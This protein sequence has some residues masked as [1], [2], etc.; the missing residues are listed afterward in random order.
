MLWRM[1]GEAMSCRLGSE[2]PGVRVSCCG[3]P[4]RLESQVETT[5]AS[6]SIVVPILLVNGIVTQEQDRDTLRPPRLRPVTLESFQTAPRCS[7]VAQ[8]DSPHSL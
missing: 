7:D 8:R 2:S 4:R 1:L 3:A 5:S 6:F